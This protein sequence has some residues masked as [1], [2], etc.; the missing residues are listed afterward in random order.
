M[1][2]PGIFKHH[3]KLDYYQRLRWT[4]LALMLVVVTLPLPIVAGTVYHYYQT[5]VRATVEGNLKGV[6]EKRREAIEVF[7]SEKVAYLQTLARID[8]FRA[9]PS[10]KDLER[11]FAVVRPLSASF[12]DMGLIDRRGRQVAYVG[13]YR[14]RGKD[15]RNAPWFQEVRQK[16]VSISDIFLGFRHLPH[17]AIAV[18]GGRPEEPWYLRATINIDTLK[19]LLKPG[20]TSVRRYVYLL[21]RRKRLKLHLGEHPTPDPRSIHPPPPGRI[22]VATVRTPDGRPL[23][24]AMSWLNQ[25]RWLLLVAEHPSSEFVSLYHARRVALVLFFSTVFIVGILAY[26]TAHWIVSRIQAADR[27]KDLIQEHLAQTS[28]LVALGK[29]AAGLAHEINNPLAIINESAGYARELMEAAEAKRRQLSPQEKQEIHTVLADITAET[30]RGKEITQRLLGFARRV[31]AKMEQVQIN[32]LVA[33]LLKYYARILAKTGNVRIE[34]HYDRDLPPVKT[35]PSQLQQVL[36]NLIDNAIYFTGQK[37][38][39]VTVSTQ[40]TPQ[41]VR[42]MVC[43]DGPGMSHS[44]KEKIFD[45]FFTTKPVGKGTGLGLAICYGIVKKLGGEIF[46]ESEPDKGATFVIKLPYHPPVEEDKS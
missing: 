8:G 26:Y 42:I 41:E 46:V 13:P 16:G 35:D 43:D 21:D 44:V 14:L 24:T 3:R 11:L 37:G 15:Y 45:P 40:A 33:E 23:L 4:I 19:R 20:E 38:G 7:L 6:V 34:E 9:A 32:R 30:F 1:S 27:E 22:Q 2:G 31:D 28:K 29:L 12:V 25:G 36:I 10:Q 5:Y 17:L 39:T 18:R